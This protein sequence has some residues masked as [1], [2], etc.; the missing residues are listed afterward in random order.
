[1]GDGMVVSICY[2]LQLSHNYFTGMGVM[3][4]LKGIERSA[5]GQLEQVNMEVSDG[6]DQ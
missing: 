6:Q 4:V 1:M 2:L 3:A 5:T